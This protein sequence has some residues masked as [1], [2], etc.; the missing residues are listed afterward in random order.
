[1][2]YRRPRKKNSSGGEDP[3]EEQLSQHQIRGRMGVSAAALQGEGLNK[4]IVFSQTPVFLIAGA[5]K[6]TVKWPR[7]DPPI[8]GLLRFHRSPS[9]VT[10]HDAQNLRL[11]AGI[12]YLEAGVMY[13]KGQNIIRI[14]RGPPLGDPSL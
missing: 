14:F 5:G 1:M 4:R 8:R 10:T 2:T 9:I 13:S 6:C 12:V 3:W 11:L 7:P